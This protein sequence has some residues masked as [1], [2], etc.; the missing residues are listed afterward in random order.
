MMGSLHTK[1]FLLLPQFL[2]NWLVLSQKSFDNLE[3][4]ELL[5]ALPGAPMQLRLETAGAVFMR[6]LGW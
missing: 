4:V 5:I 2:N 3:M 1:Q 6:E